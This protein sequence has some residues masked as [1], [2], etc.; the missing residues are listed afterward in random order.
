M[1]IDL[2]YLAPP[3]DSLV[4]LLKGSIQ[5]AFFAINS[6]SLAQSLELLYARLEKSLGT[7]E[8]ELLWNRLVTWYQGTIDKE[9]ICIRWTIDD[10][11]HLSCKD[12]AIKFL[13]LEGNTKSAKCGTFEWSKKESEKLSANHILR[14]IAN[15]LA[16]DFVVG[17]QND[18]EYDTIINLH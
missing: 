16:D 12:Q 1:L 7:S 14:Q 8:A 9:A 13:R 5:I 2:D 17:H 3:T 11:I 18:S 15:L 6:S 4:K 10:R